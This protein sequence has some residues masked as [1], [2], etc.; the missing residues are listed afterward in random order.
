MPSAL[1]L[2]MTLGSTDLVPIK[3]G[4]IDYPLNCLVEGGEGAA[5]PISVLNQMEYMHHD[6]NRHPETIRYLGHFRAG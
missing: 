6:P 2:F 1:L 4:F 5:T 3:F